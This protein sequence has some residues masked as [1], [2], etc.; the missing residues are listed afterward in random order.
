MADPN[1]FRQ[2]REGDAPL[3]DL[4]SEPASATVRQGEARYRPLF[5]DAPSLPR[6]RRSAEPGDGNRDGTEQATGGPSRRKVIVLST[7]LLVGLVGAATFGT[8]GWRIA[9]Q[10]DATLETPARVAGLTLDNSE[11]ARETADYLE[12]G[13][14]ADIRLD[15]SIGAVY[16]DPGAPDRSVLLF[17][18]TTLI[19]QPE[20]D[21]DRLFELVSDDQSTVT[22]LTEVPAGTLGGVMKCGGTSAPEGELVVCGWADHGSVAL[23]MFP[24][25]TVNES[26]ELLREIREG[27][28]TRG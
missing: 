20:R 6:Q 28:Q 12:T 24:D 17:G 26:A 22:N 3:I 27:I 9:Q 14:A 16:A 8:A 1:A 13:F 15:E 2:A 18:G 4:D 10:R 19:W 7:A 25:R 11:R 21:L 5:E 23:A